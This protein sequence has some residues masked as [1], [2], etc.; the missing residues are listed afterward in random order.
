MN[1]DL[2][3][4]II[5]HVLINLGVIKSYFL[6]DKNSKSILNNSFLLK[7]K[8]LFENETGDLSESLIWGCQFKY[9]DFDF[10][11]LISDCTQ[12]RN[13][14]EFC[15]I[16][17]PKDAPTYGLYYVYTGLSQNINNEVMLACLIGE[18]GWVQCDTLM[19]ASFLVGMEKLKS[20]NVFWSKCDS[21]QAEYEKMLSFIKYHSGFFKS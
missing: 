21:Y 7:E 15:A 3:E 9:T 5:K 20:L 1:K 11:I 17:Q 16:I 2:L 10:K 8:I 12:D 18:N 4:Q 19:Q 13:I 14:P 6:D